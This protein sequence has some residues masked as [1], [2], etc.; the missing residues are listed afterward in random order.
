MSMNL[1]HCLHFCEGGFAIA[2]HDWRRKSV[3]LGEAT[4][5]VAHWKSFEY[6][7]TEAA[8]SRQ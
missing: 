5:T 4:L 6:R 2:L 8:V 1:M 7:D 3:L